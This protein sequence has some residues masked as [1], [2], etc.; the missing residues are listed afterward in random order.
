LN[1]I[2]SAKTVDLPNG[3][4]WKAWD[5]IKPLHAPSNHGTKNN[6]IQRINHSTLY[7]AGQPPDELDIIHS[8]LLI[9]YSHDIS[10]SD[11]FNHIIYNL[12][13]K[14]Y[15]ITLAMIK[16]EMND[17]S[18]VPNLNNLKRDMRQILY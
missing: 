6:L 17:P 14:I 8:E 4:A 7:H 18:Y 10:E 13:P 2:S 11:T 5:N 15:E 9:Q 16:R 1:A 3:F 12:K